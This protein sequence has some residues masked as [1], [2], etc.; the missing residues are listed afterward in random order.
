MGHQR[1]L[2]LHDLFWAWAFPAQSALGMVFINGIIFLVL[3]VT[4]VRGECSG[5]AAFAGKSQSRRVSD[6]SLPS[7]ACRMAASSW[8]IRRRWCPLGDLSSP[9]VALFGGGILLACVLVASAD[10][11]S[12]H[13]S[14]IVIS[15]IGLMVPDGKGDGDKAAGCHRFGSRL[16]GTAALQAEFRLRPPESTESPSCYSHAAPR[17]YVRQYWHLD[18]G[19]PARG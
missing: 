15:V 2:C 5:A 14:M 7:S 19:D 9:P 13:H 1:L 18:R 8:R 3:S 6:C 17:R 16:S 12:H 4:G 11:R 10:S